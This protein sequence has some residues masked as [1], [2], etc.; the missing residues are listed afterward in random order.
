MSEIDEEML[1]DF[2]VEGWEQIETLDQEFVHLEEDSEDV[3]RVEGIFRV[4]HTLKGGA[5]FLNL[6]KHQYFLNN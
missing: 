2:L 6:P 1:N 5:G 4:M 3:K